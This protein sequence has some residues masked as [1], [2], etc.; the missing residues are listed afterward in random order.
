MSDSPAA[1]LCKA[2]GL[3]CNG[4]LFIWVK[5]RPSELD[6]AE[7]LGMQVFRSDPNQRGFGQPCPLWQ[8]EC[9]IYTS[10][11]YPHACR[12]YKCA[13]LKRVIAQNIPLP[14]AL[15]AVAQTQA[16]IAALEALLPASGKSNFRERLVEQLESGNPAA[17]LL[18][19]ARALLEEFES[20]YGV[21]D[22]LEKPNR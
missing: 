18:P 17:G 11:H 12:A 22:L 15:D 6:P 9:T 2:C 19:Q 3:C 5:L 16:H 21:K 8:G 20:V 13:L 1:T 10:R 7:A 4:R 14:Q